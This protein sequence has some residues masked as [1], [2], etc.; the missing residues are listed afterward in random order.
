MASEILSLF[1][2]QPIFDIQ[3]PERRRRRVGRVREMMEDMH[4]PT[5]THVLSYLAG[6]FDGEGCVSIYGDGRKTVQDQP[7]YRLCVCIA[8]QHRPVLELFVA[9]FGGKIYLS[10]TNP[11]YHRS[12]YYRLPY[13]CHKGARVL[14][15]LK[16]FL[17]IKADQ[18]DL[19]IKFQSTRIR[20]KGQGFLHPLFYYEEA[21]AMRQLMSELNHRDSISL[22]RLVQGSS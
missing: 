14:T 17:R 13:M 10:H 9:T 4:V 19:G 2:Y 11:K 8:I 21:H 16:P 6:I 7:L 1:D 15:Y 20:R 18:A 5:D 12:P 22:R 3:R